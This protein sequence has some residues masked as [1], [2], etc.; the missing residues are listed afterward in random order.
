MN[1]VKLHAH[2]GNDGILKLKIP[3][4]FK[5]TDVD[6]VINLAATANQKN[7]SL[8]FFEKTFGCLPDF[9]ERTQQANYEI[10]ETLE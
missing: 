3:A 5:N 1:S 7:W 6:V 4:A 8:G 9:P 10:R 2:V